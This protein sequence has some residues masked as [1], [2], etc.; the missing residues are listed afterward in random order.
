MVSTAGICAGGTAS[1]APSRKLVA[2]FLACTLIPGT[3][4][5]ILVNFKFSSS[6]ALLCGVYILAMYYISNIQRK[7]YF[8]ALL[9]NFKLEEQAL[10]LAELTTLDALTGLRNRRFFEE[11]QLDEFRRAQREHTEIALILLDIDHFKQINDRH[12]HLIGDECLREMARTL[13]QKF[14]RSMDTLARIGGEEFAVLLPGTSLEHAMTLANELRKHVASIKLNLG[15][16][17]IHMTASFGVAHIMPE[18]EDSVSALFEA[19][20]IALYEAKRSGRNRVGCAPPVSA[21]DT[22]TNRGNSDA[23]KPQPASP[24]T[25][26]QAVSHH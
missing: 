12:G 2:I 13:M 16:A 21:L 19:A 11:R 9:S 7:E 24:H 23:K 1:L 8:N 10:K 14:N 25:G 3:T 18:H 22:P 5:L 6:I 20:D 17:C 4:A 15:D 26:V